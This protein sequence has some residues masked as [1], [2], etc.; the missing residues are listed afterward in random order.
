MRM[1]AKIIL[2][3]IIG[4][5]INL[6]FYKAFNSFWGGYTCGLIIMVMLR[7]IIEM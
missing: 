6:A 7:L 2:S 4:T 1:I 3:L 5:I